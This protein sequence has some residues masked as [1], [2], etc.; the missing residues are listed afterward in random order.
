MTRPT[1]QEIIAIV[2]EEFHVSV[3]KIP[4]FNRE[5]SLAQARAAI[6]VVAREFGHPYEAIGSRMNRSAGVM[7]EIATKGR[8]DLHDDADFSAKVMDV[9]STINVRRLSRVISA[10]ELAYW[11]K[12]EANKAEI[13]RLRKLG[14]SDKS[15]SRR[16][17]IPVEVIRPV[18]GLRAEG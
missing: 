1:M 16:Y 11:D 18:I 15:L 10:D 14:W 12:I 6:A 13:L 2:A 3:E 8:R 5:R 9:R 17:Q 7:H 4:T